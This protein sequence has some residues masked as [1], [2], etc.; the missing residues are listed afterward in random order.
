MTPRLPPL[1]VPSTLVCA[2]AFGLALGRSTPVRGLQE[3][4]PAP[5]SP[6][7]VAV[8]DRFTGTDVPGAT[9]QVSVARGHETHEVALER[10]GT[11]RWR[12]MGV[13]GVDYQVRGTAFG[14]EDGESTVRAGSGEERVVLRLVPAPIALPEIRAYG[15]REGRI[16]TAHVMSRED[17][18]LRGR[19][20]G[21]WLRD[22]PG[23]EV[24]GRGP[25]GRT[26]AS[27]RGSRPAAVEVTLDGVPLTD[28]LTG[29][30]DLSLVP[31]SSLEGV[32]AT[33]GAGD[34]AGWAGSS[35]TI[36][37]QSRREEPGVRAG[38]T[39]GSFGRVTT[40]ASFG[41]RTPGAAVDGSIRYGAARNDF[42]FD[43][44][45]L[46]GRPVERRANSDYSSWGG[47]GRVSLAALPLRVLARLDGVERG[48]PGRMGSRIWDFARWKE[49]ALT[50]GA[51]LG[52]TGA[53]RSRRV[54]VSWARRTQAYT[55]ARIDREDESRADQLVAFGEEPLPAA[56]DL[57]W[58][59]TWAR[60]YGDAVSAATARAF[61][62]VRVARVQELSPAWSVDGAL[63][64]DVSD[65]RTAVS[66]TLGLSWRAAAG[67][68]LW[69]RAGQGMRLPTF[70]D[71]F[72]RTG[73][74]GVPNP[75][76]QPER[77]V[78]DTEIGV[79]HEDEGRR[80]RVSGTTFFRHTRDPIVWLPSVVAVWSPINAGRLTAYGLETGL[81]WT[82]YEGWVVG[83][84][85]TF[86]SSRLAFE[87]YSSPMPYLPAVSGALSLERSGAGGRVRADLELKGARRTSIYGPHEL[88]PLA[89]LSLRAN[90]RVHA[91]G[92]EA[93][94]EVGLLNV[95][96]VAYERVELFPEPGRS[97]E[98]RLEL[99]PAS[100][101]NLQSNRAGR[102]FRFPEGTPGAPIGPGTGDSRRNR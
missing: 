29:V 90:R 99:R 86:Q 33:A 10:I 100:R 45:V 34:G 36:R 65:V 53:D 9:V 20:L 8:I 98:V 6:V 13:S 88:P 101:G 94:V 43:N 28:P 72:L 35:G 12:F 95:L 63:A 80:V 7:S 14:Y 57:T 1:H 22:L 25:G 52:S 54:S 2:L 70:G 102:S 89:L 75:D 3:P 85:G 78:M 92:F 26:V 47:L 60:V 17:L 91:L 44:R 64:L 56:V 77:V 40:D 4:T 55:D 97:M 67:T 59:V 93:V 96:D 83:A 49:R 41:V 50:V 37:L 32:V 31:A 27:I 62:G 69:A 39:L 58:R 5:D 30:A 68:R 42:S 11:S 73:V 23:F 51:A 21:D 81:A 46:P 74:G 79:S 48:A 24:T 87:G 38:V 18:A 16:G 19:D 84:S 82:P 66:P 71:R 61:G 76:L 15:A